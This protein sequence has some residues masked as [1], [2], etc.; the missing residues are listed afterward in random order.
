MFSS[1]CCCNAIM[2]K[3]VGRGRGDGV[4]VVSIETKRGHETGVR[5]CPPKPAPWCRCGTGPGPIHTSGVNR[6]NAGCYVSD[7]AVRQRIREAASVKRN[8]TTSC[9]PP[10]T[11]Q[12]VVRGRPAPAAAPKLKHTND[13]G[14]DMRGDQQPHYT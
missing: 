11:R 14:A 2:L 4:G 10:H 7:H 3:S 13:P 8:P 5:T 12:Q 6:K 9:P 1:V